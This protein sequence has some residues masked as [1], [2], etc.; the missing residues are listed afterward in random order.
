LYVVD[1]GGGRE[2]E[3]AKD[4]GARRLNGILDWVY[5][6]EVDGGGVYRA[7]WWSP[8]STRLAFLQLDETGVPTFPVVA[9]TEV[10]PELEQEYYPQAGDPNPKARLGVVTIGNGE[11][12][13]V[14]GVRYR[15]EDEILI[16][17]VG[18]TPDSRAVIYQVQNRE[19]TW[20]DLNSFEL[21]R[22]SSRTLLRETSK[23]WVDVIGLPIWLQDGSFLWQSARSGY[24][25][26]YHHAG[27]GKLIKAVT[28]GDWAVANVY[29]A[30]TANGWVYFAA[31]R[32]NAVDQHLYRIKLD[33]TGLTRLTEKAGSHSANFNKAF[34]LFADTWSDVRTPQQAALYRTEK[35]EPIRALAEVG[36]SALKNYELS[37]VEFLQVKAADGFPLEAAMIKPPDFDASRKHPVL[38]YT[39]AGPQAPTVGNRWGG[40][41]Y[42]WHQ[43]LAQ[44]GYIIWEIDPRSASAK[45]AALAWPTHRNLGELELRDIEA[46]LEWLKKQPYVDGSRIGIWGW[47]YGGFMAAYALTHSRSF[48]AG[49]A[50]AP[51]TDWRLYDSIYTERYMG[52]PA[53]NREGYEKS[54]VVKAAKDLHGRL[55]LVHGLIDDNVHIQNSV[56]FMYELQQAGKDFD[57]MFY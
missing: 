8:D 12:Q 32:E 10:D 11:N 54:S 13:W 30:D 20:L 6:E 55:L 17:R 22:K 38:V 23:A 2:N 16:V 27:D 26:I 31:R 37:P 28:T 14:E 29:G 52:L 40:R 1:V 53:K 39:Y 4:G 47:S 50:G 15:L 25:H 21:G 42:L 56:M 46:S 7:L 3:L 41:T 44:K 51:V 33:G 18:W 36:E 24:T 9:Q 43:F 49:I 34:T 45:S 48:K 57:V 19:Q 35:T 5:Q